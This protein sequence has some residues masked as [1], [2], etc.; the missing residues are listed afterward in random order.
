[1]A[2]KAVGET[3]KVHSFEPTDETFK[4][5]E[6]SVSLNKCQ[7]IT[8]HQIALSNIKEEREFVISKDGFD[9]YNSLGTPSSGKDFDRK[10]VITHSLDSYIEEHQLNLPS[11]VKIDVE[12][13]EIPVIEG[14]NAILSNDN[15]PTL[16]KTMQ[17]FPVFLVLSSTSLFLLMVIHCMNT[18]G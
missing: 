16:Q 14:M 5:L 3:G 2:S 9:A 6:E 4:R 17:S 12:G 11:L 1:M 7:N 8:T 10:V 18:I 13:W 15:A